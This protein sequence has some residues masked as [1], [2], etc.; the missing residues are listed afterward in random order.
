MAVAKCMSGWS[1][2]L[3][4][5]TRAENNDHSCEKFS[6]VCNLVEQQKQQPEPLKMKSGYLDLPDWPFH[7]F[8]ASRSGDRRIVCSSILK[9]QSWERI[10]R[11]T[12]AEE[13][14]IEKVGSRRKVREKSRLPLNK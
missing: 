12:D 6:R 14:V 8:H 9:L 1:V 3:Y 10:G 11:V 5:Y 2:T 13:E 7:I 4:I